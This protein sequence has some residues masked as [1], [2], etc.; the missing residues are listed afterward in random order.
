MT[1]D[2][3][4]QDMPMTIQGRRRA[5]LQYGNGYRCPA[6]CG[7]Q[8]A[9]SQTN[10]WGAFNVTSNSIEFYSESIEPAFVLEKGCR[11]RGSGYGGRSNVSGWT[12]RFSRRIRW[13]FA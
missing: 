13:K 8:A 11:S 3:Q 7:R 1:L 6:S 5:T 10:F 12:T 2:L 9:H 4:E